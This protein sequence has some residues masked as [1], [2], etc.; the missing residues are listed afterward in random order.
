VLV[1]GNCDV[2]KDHCIRSNGALYY[3]NYFEFEGCVD[4]LLKHEEEKKL[5]SENAKKYVEENYRW[6]I[7]CERLCDL[8]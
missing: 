3:Q 5:M 1:N 6:D 4:Y 2:L 7:I 8:I